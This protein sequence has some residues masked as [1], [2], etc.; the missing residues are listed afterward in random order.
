MKQFALYAGGILLV[1]GALLP[2]FLPTVA[3]YLFAIGALLLHQHKL[4]TAMKGEIS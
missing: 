1:A 3:P 2:L 4:P